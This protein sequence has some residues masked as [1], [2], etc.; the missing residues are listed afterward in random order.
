[1]PGLC[2]NQTMSERKSG[3]MIALLFLAL[4]GLLPADTGAAEELARGTP[5]NSVACTDDTTQSYALY[6]PSNYSPERL[7]PIVY[8]FDP[9]GR[10]DYPVGLFRAAA[11]KYGYIL[12]GSNNSQNGPWEPIH[13]A[14]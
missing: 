3:S 5:I 9:G 13:R 14:V 10:G 2:N 6:L 4:L 7:W 8:C 1:M 12:V 11:E